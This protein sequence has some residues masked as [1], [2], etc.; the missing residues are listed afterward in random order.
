MV[1]EH[2]GGRINI[3]DKEVKI[4]YHV[5]SALPSN[6]GTMASHQLPSPQQTRQAADAIA[7]AMADNPYAVVGG[8]ACSVLGSERVT[9]DV[10]FV[11]PQGGTKAARALLRGFEQL[12]EIEK[13]TNHTYYKST[14]PVEVEILTPPALFKQPFGPETPVIKVQ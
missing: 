3:W 8:A 14:P 7:Y 13:R 12:F 10:D 1:Y 9:S 2:L 6:A 11:V 5:L 4:E